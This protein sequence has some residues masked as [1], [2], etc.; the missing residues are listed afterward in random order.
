MQSSIWFQT[1]TTE[2]SRTLA[3]SDPLP[4]T[5][6]VVIVGAGL[7]GLATAY[8]LAAEGVSGICVL[9]REAAMAEASGANAGGLWFA[10]QSP[11][12]GPLAP[13][14]LA[15]SRLYDGLAAKFDFDFRRTGLLELLE[16][17]PDQGVIERVRDAGFRVAPV[18]AEDLPRL[19]PALAAGAAGALFYPDEAQVNP[20]KLGAGW[21]RW[22]K[23]KGVKFCFGIEVERVRPRVETSRGALDAGT[24]VIASGAW[25]PL[26][27]KTLGWT[28]PI[29]PLRGQL[30][31]TV[32][33]EPL[34][35][36]TVIARHYYY[37]QLA[38]GHL[39]G[40]GT[41]E[42]VGFERG[43]DPQDVAAIRAEMDALFPAVRGTQ[44]ARA[45]SGFRPHCAD[46]RPVVGRVPG[47]EAVF[48]AAG[49]FKKG[50][51][52]APVTGKILARMI[53]G[54]GIDLP[55]EPLSPARFRK[56]ER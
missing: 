10:Q 24:V 49:H 33:L 31:A 27:T 21:V 52:L 2:Q 14:A 17:E 48:V 25:T 6:E 23:N 42:D 5:A 19:E 53:T 55:L 29:K 38:E 41:V 28:P 9:D 18:A 51:M 30:L 22:L 12:L 15:G 8:Y 4:Q 50:V 37:W 26:V 43:V 36:H 40:G 44:T 45:W 16:G 39:A 56:I 13:L 7:I 3:E 20:V 32:P 11:E 1:I 34:L 47:Q 54:A 46:L 35:E